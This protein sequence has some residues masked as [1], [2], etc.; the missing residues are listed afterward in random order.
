MNKSKS[1]LE[2]PDMMKNVNVVMIPKPK[3]QGLHHIENQRGIFLISVFRS[4]LMKL[5]LKDEYNTI[6]SYMSDS[7]VG[8]RK[9]RR[10]QDHIF[11]INGIIFEHARSNK[12]KQISVCIYDCEQC[13]DSMWQDEVTNNLY[14]AGVKSDKLSLLQKINKVNI[15]PVKHLM[16]YHR[17]K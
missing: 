2:I 8:G 6:D 11:I 15:V 7:N 14:D 16:N 9:G 5:L 10:A 1:L 3:K 4:I 17:E 12:K 13:F